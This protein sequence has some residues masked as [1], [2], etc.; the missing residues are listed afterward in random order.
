MSIFGQQVGH[1]KTLIKHKK[2]VDFIDKTPEIDGVWLL[3]YREDSSIVLTKELLAENTDPFISPN[4]PTYLLTTDNPQ[5]E[6]IA[7]SLEKSKRELF[8]GEDAKYFLVKPESIGTKIA[9]NY[10]YSKNK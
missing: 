2:L 9:A 4:H 5:D 1:Q 7:Q 10:L 6:E 3:P 8:I